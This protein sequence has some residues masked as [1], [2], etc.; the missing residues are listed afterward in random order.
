MSQWTSRIHPDDRDDLLA[1]VDAYLKSDELTHEFEFRFRHRDGSYR[2]I[3]SRGS[4]LLDD[5]GVPIRALGAHVDI[6]ERAEMQA[7]IL[8]AQKMET[9]GQLAGGIA[10]DFNNLLTVI[11]G[12]ADPALVYLK[13]TDT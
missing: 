10:H 2:R 11:N 4:K 12:T 3:L 6:T 8:Q 7:Q 1:R 13:D 5:Q 9:V